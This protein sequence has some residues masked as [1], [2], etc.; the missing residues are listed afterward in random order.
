VK[1]PLKRRYTSEINHVMSSGGQGNFTL[2][3]CVLLGVNDAL[4]RLA[5]V[6][7]EAKRDKVKSGRLVLGARPL[8]KGLFL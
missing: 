8:N 5:H 1:C 4:R 6:V 7:N 2:D 3:D